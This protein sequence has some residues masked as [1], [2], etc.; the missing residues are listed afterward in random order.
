MKIYKLLAS[1]LTKPL[2]KVSA[3]FCTPKHNNKL[4]DY[5]KF[6]KPL[7]NSFIAGGDYN[8]KI[9]FWGSRLTTTKGGVLHKVMK[10]NNLKNLSTRQPTYRPSNPDTISDLVVFCVTKG[11]GTKNFT[12]ELCLDLA[13]DPTQILINMFTPIPG[14]SKKR[15]LYSN[16][17]DWNCFRETLGEQ[18]TLEI[19]LKTEIDIEESVENITEAIQNAAWQA[20]PGR[21]EQNSKE[22]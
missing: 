22:E 6:F 14:T 4:D 10:N 5:D 11:I 21:N 15:S 2:E 18:I 1:P 17:T 8:A 12:L 13:S 20:T 16:K 7:G 19:P 9:T 3:N